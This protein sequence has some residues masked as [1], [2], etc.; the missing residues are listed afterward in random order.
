MIE[1]AAGN[2]EALGLDVG[3]E[4]VRR[5]AVLSAID[6]GQPTLTGPIT[7]KQDERQRPGVL[8]LLPLYQ[9]SSPH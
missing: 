4:P 7:L 9:G 8:Y 1:P 3:A 2:Q 6:S 5:A